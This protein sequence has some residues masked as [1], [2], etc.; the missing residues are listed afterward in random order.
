[1][2]TTAFAEHFAA[3]WIDAWNSRDLERVL[4]H[5]S[6]D[7]EMHSPVII[8]VAGEPS[9]R[10]KG[11]D[12]VSAYWAKALGLIPDLHFEPVATLIGVDSITLYYK[13]ARG[14]LAAEV[15]HFGADGKVHTA[16]A[17][18]AP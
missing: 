14:R 5:Y 3:D 2:I 1:M 12:A 10:L 9:G 8:Q 16:F 13:G 17:H 18:Y 7:F 4:S 6:D 11:K 15:F